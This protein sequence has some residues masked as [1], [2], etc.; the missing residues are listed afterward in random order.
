MECAKCAETVTDHVVCGGCKS[1]YDFPCAGIAETTYRKMGA[2]KKASWRCASCRI[3]T[4]HSQSLIDNM[5]IVLSEIKAMRSD[6]SAMKKDVQDTS[7]A[8]SN[9]SSKWDDLQLRFTAMDARVGSVENKVDLLSTTQKELQ[10]ANKTIQELKQDNNARDQF[11]RMNNIE[12]SG[13]PTTKGEN[14]VSLLRDICNKVGFVLQDAEVDTIHRVRR[15]TSDEAQK[16][17]ARP[18]AIIARFVLRRRK[19][20]LLAAMRVRRGLTTQ[21]IGL[22]GA[23]ANIYI[24]DH[25]TRDNKMLLKRARE[26]KSELNY[27]YLWVRDCKIMMRKNDKSKFIEI[28]SESDLLKLH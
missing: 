20:A 27:S 5:N 26:I 25:L 24:N 9:L 19:D 13:I 14:L 23:P 21:D 18:P 7:Q 28:Q 10:C 22:Q 1:I 16:R 15:F 12:I 17:D 2:D 6:F 3:T 4:P 8:V 11:S